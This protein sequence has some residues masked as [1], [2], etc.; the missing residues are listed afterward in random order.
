[1]HGCVA[2]LDRLGSR[3]TC[4]TSARGYERMQLTERSGSNPPQRRGPAAPQAQSQMLV[5]AF[6]RLGRG[7]WSSSNGT[8][9]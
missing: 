1:M 4:I 9:R 3:A 5:L 2:P 7:R 6:I 8:Y